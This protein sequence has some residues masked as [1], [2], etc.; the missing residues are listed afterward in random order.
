ML[1][2]SYI[3][4]TI[5]VNPG[6]ASKWKNQQIGESTRIVTTHTPPCHMLMTMSV[7]QGHADV[8]GLHFSPKL[9]L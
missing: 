6:E 4:L 5:I 7:A 1:M 3:H 9:W 8:L 2:I